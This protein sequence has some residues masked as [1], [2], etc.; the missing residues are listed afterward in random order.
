MN[1]SEMKSGVWLALAA[2]HS[3]SGLRQA[4]SDSHVDW[5]SMSGM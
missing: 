1:S 3:H 4:L 2:D 5:K